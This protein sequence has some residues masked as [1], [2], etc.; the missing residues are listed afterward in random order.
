M[1]LRQL[2]IYSLCLVVGALFADAAAAERRVALVVGNSAYKNAS[3]LSNTINDSSAIAA[4]FRSIGFEV[5]ISRNDLGVVEFKRTVREFLIT[6]ENADIA[7]VY[8]AGHGIEISGT[9]YLVPVDAR[10]SRDYDVDDEAISLDRIIWALQPVRRLRLILLDACR[11]NPFAAKL[12]SAGRTPA[13]GGL[14]KLDDVGADTLVAYAAK[15]GSISYDGDGVN[16]PYAIALLRHLAEPGVDI[17]ITLGRVRDA[18]IAMTGGRQEPFIYGS[19]GGA[20]ISLV[21][22]TTRVAP[23]LPVVAAPAPPSASVPSPSNPAVVSPAPVPPT[24]NATVPRPPLPAQAAPQTVDPCVR[25][26]ARLA[27]LRA[28]P[29]PEEIINFQR[30]VACTRLRPQVQ[31]LFESFV[32]GTALPSGGNP[33]AETVP[34]QQAQN[35]S[36]RSEDTCSR[37]MARLLSMRAEPTLEAI[38]KFEKELGCERLRSQLRRLRESLSP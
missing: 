38:T 10:L 5:V 23:A 20:T 19:L 3:T 16:S 1:K 35:E 13:R 27:R 7:V 30:E 28:N 17:R 26:E 11:D 15:A 9:N 14:A 2:L 12:R 33:A 18:V 36:V 24:V 29:A 34:K 37:D 6:A 31:R 8:Y 25:D 21:P 4:L 32:G 22:D